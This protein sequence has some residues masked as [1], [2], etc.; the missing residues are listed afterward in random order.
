MLYLLY[1]KPAGSCPRKLPTKRVSGP[2]GLLPR[3]PPH[4]ITESQESLPQEVGTY[5]ETRK[6]SLFQFFEMF[7]PTG[8]FILLFR[9]P[10]TFFHPNILVYT[11]RRSKPFYFPTIFCQIFSSTHQRVVNIRISR[12]ERK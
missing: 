8:K 11:S 1:G 10:Y 4:A 9:P 3:R 6:S 12:V 5:L 2:F 7:K